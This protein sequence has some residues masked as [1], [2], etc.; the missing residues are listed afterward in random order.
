MGEGDGWIGFGTYRRPAYLERGLRSAL[1]VRESQGMVVLDDDPDSSGE[2]VVAGL[3]RELGASVGYLGWGGKRRLVSALQGTLRRAGVDP[4]LLDFALLGHSQFAHLPLKANRN[5]LF[6][7]AAGTR[8]AGLDEDVNWETASVPGALNGRSSP[9]PGRAGGHPPPGTT[10]IRFSSGRDPTTPRPFPSR[11]SLL[12]AYPLT[13]DDPIP[14]LVAPLGWNPVWREE[15]GWRAGSTSGVG[16]E[17][18]AGR[19]PPD[20][21]DASSLLRRRLAQGTLRVVVSSLPV[22]GHTGS[23]S[24]HHRLLLPAA[25]RSD[26][27]EDPGVYASIRESRWE[28]RASDL[29]TISDSGFLQHTSAAYDL[30]RTLPPFFPHLPRNHDGVQGALIPMSRA[31]DVIW[32]GN[33]GIRHEGPLDRAFGPDDIWAGAAQWGLAEVVLLLFSQVEF[34][35]DTEEGERVRRLAAMLR[36]A[37]G[38]DEGAFLDTLGPLW[39]G[40]LEGRLRALGD[41]YDR[42]GGHPRWWGEDVERSMDVVEEALAAQQPGPPAAVDGGWPQVQALLGW[43]GRLLE[44]WPAIF[45]AAVEQREEL[46]DIPHIPGA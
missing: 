38:V 34:L 12:A 25:L 11:E 1:A 19:P 13:P 35:P 17:T 39:R 7:L 10:A 42:F 21:E 40:Y 37:S 29:P 15:E 18:A 45:Q 43:Y 32:V 30:T 27:E 36:E 3:N 4:A 26:W 41:V 16:S 23:R 22:W 46:S 28:L 33:V 44:A 6:L 24:L 31:G 5:A 2:G 8:A 9:T 20:L 14:R